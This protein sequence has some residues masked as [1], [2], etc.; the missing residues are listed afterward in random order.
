VVDF[1]RDDPAASGVLWA[2]KKTAQNLD[3]STVSLWR[4]RQ[5][6]DF[7][8]PIIINHRLY[9]RSSE[10]LAWV[11]ALPAATRQEELALRQRLPTRRPKNR[12]AKTAAGEP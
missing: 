4:L 7:P 2:T 6:P 10:V 5:R 3:V 11:R 12:S 9:W 1:S 8:A